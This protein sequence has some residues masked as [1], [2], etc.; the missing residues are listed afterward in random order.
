MQPLTGEF[1]EENIDSKVKINDDILV[2]HK[3][4]GQMPIKFVRADQEY[5]FLIDIYERHNPY[6]VMD[7]RIHLKDID[8]IEIT[9]RSEGVQS[10]GFWENYEVFPGEIDGM[11]LFF[12]GVVPLFLLLLLLWSLL[13][14]NYENTTAKQPINSAYKQLGEA[15]NEGGFKLARLRSKLPCSRSQHRAWVSPM[16]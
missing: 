14:C 4:Q 7:G 9:K 2:F 11:N 13:E 3:T 15:I 6:S 12:W 8:R 5:L 10:D 1:T 16:W